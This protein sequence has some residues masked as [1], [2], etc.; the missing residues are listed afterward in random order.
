LRFCEFLRLRFP[1]REI[2]PGHYRHF[3]RL[4]E[5]GEKAG[6]LVRHGYERKWRSSIRAYNGD[7]SYPSDKVGSLNRIPEEFRELYVVNNRSDDPRV[8]AL[9]KGISPY[10]PTWFLALA[11]P[12]RRK[13]LPVYCNF[14]IGQPSQPAYVER[15]RKVR[16]VVQ[17]KEWMTRENLGNTFGTYDMTSVQYHWRV[18]EHRF[19]VSPEGNG[20]DCHRTWEA[21]Y[22]RSIPIVQYSKEMEHFSD[23]PIL[24][25]QDYTELTSEYL[26]EQYERIL[27]TDYNIEKLYASYW[28]RRVEQSLAR[29]GARSGRD[30]TG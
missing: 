11:L 29:A 1:I 23:L 20:V 15:R 10:R 22:L 30:F 14:S 2:I 9:P 26:S 28:L 6:V 7:E 3:L 25:T 24:F 12:R 4:Q 8:S 17:S 16:D 21:L 18:A 19:T 5:G 13:Q 27:D